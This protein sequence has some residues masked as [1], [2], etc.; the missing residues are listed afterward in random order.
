[1]RTKLFILMFF[2][3]IYR[4]NYA[5][6]T[7]LWGQLIKTK[8][9]VNMLMPLNGSTY[10]TVRYQGGGLLGSNY[11]SY[12]SN[13]KLK[14]T[15][16]IKSAVNN[17]TAIVEYV[18]LINGFPIAFLTDKVENKRLLYAQ[19]YDSTCKEID[20]PIK[21]SEYTISKNGWK[22]RGFYNFL[23]SKN[24]EYFCIEY[25]IPATKD[26]NER[27][28]YRIFSKNFELISSGEYELPF[29][30]N[31]A[32]IS[33]R[34]ISDTGDYFISVKVFEP[35][36]KKKIFK[37]NSL[38]SKV[39]L[40]Q[41]TP[42]GLIEYEL[43]FEDKKITEMTFS[44]DNN[45]IITFSGLYGDKNTSGIKGVFY[46]V[47]DFD[48]K[49]ILNEG[50]KEF[51][52]DFITED[53]TE[54]QK[55]R[56]E[57]NIEKGKSSPQLFNY[58]VKEMSTLSDGSLIGLL[59]QY[60]INTVTYTDPRGYIKTTS[61]Y[62]YNDLI[63]YKINHLG[64]FVWVKKIPKTQITVDDYGYFSSIA[65]CVNDE[66]I[67]VFFNDNSKNYDSNGVWNQKDF[68]A[69]FTRKTN[70]VAKVVIDVQTGSVNR[71][72]FVD[73]K[74]TNSISIPKLFKVD[75]IKNEMLM[76]LRYG[77]KEKYGLYKF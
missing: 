48:K 3:F 25:D 13:F 52:K 35:E 21:L 38:L 22:S 54:R 26:E 1:M 76:V 47:M 51:D 49:K 36:E 41:V 24:K 65:S 20:A 31:E 68:S 12:H 23:F 18:S 64:E 33:T 37:D 28:G 57:K 43:K 32:T 66:K 8:G 6:D 55:D 16:K 74:E 59:E 61:S 2:V 77:K 69:N 27:F 46:F 71:T 11:F 73:A 40:M 60:Y 50:F 19:K 67:V 62:N 44:S 34:Y 63:I 70:V 72:T 17:S 58:E 42:S 29:L 15:G 30:K 14:E 39:I 53:W 10:Y 75:Y 9:Q 7:T 56:S 4:N 45:R 5:Q